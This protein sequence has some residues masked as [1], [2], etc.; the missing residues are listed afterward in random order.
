MDGNFSVILDYMGKQKRRMIIS[1]TQHTVQLLPKNKLRVDGAIVEMP[2][3]AQDISV[4][5]EGDD[6]TVSGRGF[7]IHHN[8]PNDKYEIGLSGWYYGK[9]GGLL[10]TYDN[11]RHNDMMMSSRQLTSDITSFVDTWEVKDRCR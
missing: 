2:Y 7:A 6:V 5:N 10:G 3:H 4:I 8:L 11:E 1:T 9:T